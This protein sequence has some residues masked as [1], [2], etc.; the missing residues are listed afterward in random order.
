MIGI[1]SFKREPNRKRPAS[2]RR[3]DSWLRWIKP[4]LFKNHFPASLQDGASSTLT[5]DAASEPEDGDAAHPLS[6]KANL[7]PL[8]WAVP[9]LRIIAPRLVSG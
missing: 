9:G 4:K 2:F 7:G 5:L 3:E 1:Y 6:G 8:A